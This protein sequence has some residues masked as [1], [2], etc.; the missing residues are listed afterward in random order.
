MILFKH[1]VFRDAQNYQELQ[2]KI[3]DESIFVKPNRASFRVE[4][5][6]QRRKGIY[7]LRGEVNYFKPLED[8]AGSKLRWNQVIQDLQI[9]N[10]MLPKI[11]G[12]Y[13]SI[14]HVNPDE[15]PNKFVAKPN[16]G[17]G[18][19]GVYGV[20]KTENN[21]FHETFTDQILSWDELAD[22]HHKT[23]TVFKTSLGPEI[24]VEEYLLRADGTRPLDWK[25]Y[26]AGGEL[27]AFF[28]CREDLNDEGTGS[29]R[30]HG[31]WN[32]FK[33]PMNPLQNDRLVDRSVELP[34]NIDEMI[35]IAK[36]I[37]TSFARSTARIDFYEVDGK[38]YFGEYTATPGGHYRASLEQDKELGELW[39]IADAKFN[40]MVLTRL[41]ESGHPKI[42]H[43]IWRG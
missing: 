21:K 9:P 5:E 43:G 36:E 35:E 8:F 23:L 1:P 42:G 24:L 33:E 20:V 26:I 34:I 29:D 4:L 16:H 18:S 12:I 28:A 30:Y 14:A 19:H 3:N 11:Y 10:L 2:S 39:E 17:Q 27:V 22:R 40:L 25:F 38:I 32:R 31:I 37:A 15:L 6:R 13:D 7:P 41:I